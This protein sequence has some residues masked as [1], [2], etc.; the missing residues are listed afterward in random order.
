M[1]QALSRCAG[2]TFQTFSDDRLTRSNP[3]VP[4][5]SDQDYLLALALQ[6][7]DASTLASVSGATP[8]V[9]STTHLLDR[10][11]SSL[12]REHDEVSRM[13]LSDEAVALALHNEE[14]ALFQ[15]RH[16][17]NQGSASSFRPEHGRRTGDD[18]IRQTDMEPR[19]LR[20]RD[21]WGWFACCFPY[22]VAAGD[23]EHASYPTVATLHP[24]LLN[25]ST[26]ML[27]PRRCA[28]FSRLDLSAQVPSLNFE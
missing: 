2:A 21:R 7:D 13:A 11:D 25:K 18:S 16:A 12:R 6:Q 4:H 27:R 20:H 19:S 15:Q 28:L 9:P 3:N 14:R 5:Y 8:R 24:S 10:T 1:Q 26:C 17:S 22:V 23:R